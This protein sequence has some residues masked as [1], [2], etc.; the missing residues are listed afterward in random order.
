MLDEKGQH[1]T[2]M[3]AQ[4]IAPSQFCTPVLVTNVDSP[5]LF[6]VSI[7]SKRTMNALQVWK[8]FKLFCDLPNP[9]VCFSSQSSPNLPWT[10]GLSDDFFFDWTPTPYPHLIPRPSSGHQ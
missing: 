10:N 2:E 8:T 9:K 5:D 6:F 1:W 4:T 3:V 7:L